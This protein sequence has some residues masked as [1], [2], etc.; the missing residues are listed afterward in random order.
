MNFF[1]IIT[2]FLALF[3]I[4]IG[5]SNLFADSHD[6]E[7]NIVDQAKEINKEIKKKQAATEAN[8]NSEIGDQEPLPL[9][10]PFAGDSS[11]GSG[12]G[13]ISGSQTEDREEMSLYNFKLVGV[14]SG[15]YDSYVSL[16]NASGDVITLQLH[17]EL[18]EGVR[19]V[20]TRL[21]EAIFEKADDTYITINFKNQIKETDEY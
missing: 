18:S 6:A 17:E 19:L 10:D 4:S 16:V 15:T 14:I 8:I 2:L 7:Q 9:N 20:D 3:F 11:F 12:T 21:N 5:P 13:I 1:R